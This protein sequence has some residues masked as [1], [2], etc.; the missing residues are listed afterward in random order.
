MIADPLVAMVIL[1]ISETSVP[2]FQVFLA[3]TLACCKYQDVFTYLFYIFPPLFYTTCVIRSVTNPLTGSHL[4]YHPSYLNFVATGPPYVSSHT[5]ILV[6][7]FFAKRF[8]LLLFSAEGHPLRGFVFP[9]VELL[10]LGRAP[11]AGD[12]GLTI[13]V[14]FYFASTE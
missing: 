11:F 2:P 13:F 5:E 6:V 10:H 1:S 7:T 3:S 4:S 8:L 14:S 12:P 9:Y